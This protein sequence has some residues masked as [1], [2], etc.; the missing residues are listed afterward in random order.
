MAGV[1]VCRWRTDGGALAAIVRDRGVLRGASAPS[2][3]LSDADVDDVGGGC[4]SGDG[5]DTAG[6]GAEATGYRFGSDPVRRSAVL[7]RAAGYDEGKVLRQEK[8]INEGL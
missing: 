4:D 6:D 8:R 7:P 2:H 3:T 5:G 1:M